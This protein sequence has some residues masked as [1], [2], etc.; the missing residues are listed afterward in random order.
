MQKLQDSELNLWCYWWLWDYL[1]LFLISDTRV[2]AWLPT[3][4]H[5]GEAKSFAPQRMDL[6]HGDEANQLVNLLA[7]LY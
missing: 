4:V 2:P 5:V 6:S 3:L 7:H 1:Q